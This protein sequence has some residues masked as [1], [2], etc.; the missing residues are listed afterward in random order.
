MLRATPPKDSLWLAGFEVCRAMPAVERSLRSRLAAPM[1][2]TGGGPA[3]RRRARAG[4]LA[5]QAGDVAGHGRARQ[6]EGS[7]ELLLRNEGIR[8]DQLVQLFFF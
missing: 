1:Q 5:D 3:A 6:A 7:G 4:A 2:V 8:A